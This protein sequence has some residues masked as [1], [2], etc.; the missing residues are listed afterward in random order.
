MFKKIVMLILIVVSTIVVG[1]AIYLNFL[2]R[3]FLTILFFGYLFLNIILLFLFKKKNRLLVGLGIIL[4][5][6]I[7]VISIGCFFILIRMHVL[8]NH[9]SQ[10][11]PEVDAYS[12]VVLK[13]SSV[14]GIDDIKDKDLGILEE[15]VDDSYNEALKGLKDNCDA[16]YKNYRHILALA[17]ALLSQEVEAIFLNQAYI[18][19][20]DEG[21]EDFSDKIRVLDTI[22]IEKKQEIIENN[23]G[24]IDNLESLNVYISGIDTYGEINTVSR[25]DVNII[26]TIN[27]RSGE[28][29]LTNIPRD[30]YV[31][32]AGK[33]GLRDKLTHAGVYGINT[34]IQTIENFLDIDIDYYVRI[35]FSSLIQLVDYLGGIDI[36]SDYDFEVAGYHFNKGM[37]YNLTGRAAL[38]FSRDR[39]SFSD[40]DRQRGR[41]QERVIAA[42]INKVTKS[43]DTSTYFKLISTLENSFQTNMDRNTMNKLINRQLE[44]NYQWEI[45]FSDINGYDSMNYTYSYPWQKLYVMEVDNDSLQEA[46]NKITNTLQK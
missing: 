5:F 29:L 9:I 16:N 28:L 42:I 14:E 33:D 10:V 17:N 39:Y 35:N 24:S 40:G 6:L 13:K 45:S 21:I 11:V 34:S 3:P 2:P 15:V 18:S 44:N 1:L 25:S 43:N 36:Y 31:N 26:A 22:K 38:Y 4:S 12:V 7:I 23:K 37:N 41:N 20:L 8:L 46:K 30:M 27:L 32:L 19:I